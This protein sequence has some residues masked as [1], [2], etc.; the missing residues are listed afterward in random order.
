MAVIVTKLYVLVPIHPIGIDVHLKNWI[1]ECKC[2]EIATVPSRLVL[3]SQLPLT[4][5]TTKCY[6]KDFTLI[7][8]LRILSS[9]GFTPTFP[10]DLNVL[11]LTITLPSL[12][13]SLPEFLRALS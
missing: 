12:L 10:I 6:W 5:L 3:T 2:M 8:T 7:L 1:N 13:H 9:L 11:R 4:L